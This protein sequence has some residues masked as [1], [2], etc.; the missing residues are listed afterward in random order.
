MNRPLPVINKYLDRKWHIKMIHHHKKRVSDTKNS[1]E[2]T[3]NTD[4]LGMTA[5]GLKKDQM[6]EDR[7]VEIAK[8]NR[9]LLEKIV[10][11]MKKDPRKRDYYN[12]FVSKEKKLLHEPFRKKEYTRIKKENIKML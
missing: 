12:E 7:C 11:I 3:L 5:R 9:I 1:F 6:I 4:P 10:S 2:T 8:D